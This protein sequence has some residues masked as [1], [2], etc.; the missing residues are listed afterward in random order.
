M[1][2]SLEVKQEYL[3][4]QIL[5][6]GYDADNFMAFLQEKKGED[7]VD[8]S[9][10]NISELKDAVTEFTSI[11]KPIESEN[12]SSDN[13]N[14]NDIANNNIDNKNNNNIIDNNNDDLEP[15]NM[16][17]IK[18]AQIK[19]YNIC[20]KT[21]VTTLSTKKNIEISV[22]FP[23]KK[24]GGMFNK[25]YISYLV[26]TQPFNYQVRKDILIFIG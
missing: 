18:N 1:D 15:V 19:E 22:G 3:R 9:N 23:E 2:D 13:N 17:L 26:T 25:S 7:G 4:T 6:K 16:D 8:L 10:W 24:E 20:I 21:E 5:D 12:N 14:Q 11:Y